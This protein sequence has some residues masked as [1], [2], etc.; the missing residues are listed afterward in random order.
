MTT[1]SAQVT[2]F[3]A[4]IS[5]IV[6]LPLTNTPL[7]L[8]KSSLILAVVKENYFEVNSSLQ[9][10]FVDKKQCINKCS[11]HLLLRDQAECVFLYFRID[12]GNNSERTEECILQNDLLMAVHYCVCLISSTYLQLQ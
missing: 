2:A 9:L 6:C 8:L 7:N 3:S 4:E 1:G 5:C 12:H 10:F 11:I